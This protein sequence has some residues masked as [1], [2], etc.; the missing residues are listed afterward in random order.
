[1]KNKMKKKNTIYGFPYMVFLN[2]DLKM[3]FH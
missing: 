2:Y 3:P 1:M